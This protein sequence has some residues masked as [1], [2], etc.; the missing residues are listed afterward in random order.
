MRFQAVSRFFIYTGGIVACLL[1]LTS[2]IAHDPVTL[3]NDILLTAAEVGGGK[4]TPTDEVELY[5]ASSCGPDSV[6]LYNHGNYSSH[7]AQY[8]NDGQT[9]VVGLW[10]DGGSRMRERIEYA[11]LE[12]E[13]NMPCLMG[14]EGSP[15]LPADSV[16]DQR[17]TILDFGDD[18]FAFQYI[19]WYNVK[20]SAPLAPTLGPDFRVFS[21]ARVYGVVDNMYIMVRIDYNNIHTHAPSEEELRALWEAQI[22]KARYHHSIHETNTTLTPQSNH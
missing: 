21:T 12:A 11:R 19:G 17:V 20:G 9:I 5:S 2:C 13:L 15:G 4:L 7:V 1:T 8:A 14:R 10:E 16:N 6:N 22:A 3:P 18:T